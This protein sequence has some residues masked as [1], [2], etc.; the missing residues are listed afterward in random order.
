MLNVVFLVGAVFPPI[1]SVQ[2][3]QNE[4]RQAQFLLFLLF[5]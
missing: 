1:S 4:T 2:K 3:A 5:F